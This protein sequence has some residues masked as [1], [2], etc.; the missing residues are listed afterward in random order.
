MLTKA[1]LS[2][3][4]TALLCTT[5]LLDFSVVFSHTGDGPKANLWTQARNMIKNQSLECQNICLA[6]CLYL[7]RGPAKSLRA[8]TLE[9][10]YVLHN[11]PRYLFLTL[12]SSGWLSLW[13]KSSNCHWFCRERSPVWPAYKSSSALFV[14]QIFWLLLQV[15]R[16]LLHTAES[17]SSLPIMFQPL[18]KTLGLWCYVVWT[19]HAYFK[20]TVCRE[21]GLWHMVKIRDEFLILS[22]FTPS[23]NKIG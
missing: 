13:C 23:N 22:R 1:P 10:L 9:Y 17:L 3:T 7:Y 19:H 2:D 18:D 16:T 11:R 4:N 6:S 21:P 8:N 5:S 12:L 14:P 20:R 15:K